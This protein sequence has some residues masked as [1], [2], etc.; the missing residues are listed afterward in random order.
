MSGSPRKLSSTTA[1]AIKAYGG[2]A[3]WKKAK[4]IEA[5]VSVSGLAPTLKGRPPFRHARIALD[6]QRP[7]VWLQPIGRQAGLIGV[8]DGADVQVQA[9]DGNVLRERKSARRYF[10]YGRRLFYWDD[11]DMSYFACYAFWNYF[12][13][14][15]LLLNDSIEW[16]EPAPGRLLATFPESIPTHS[17]RQEFLFDSETG[18]LRQ[19]NYTAEVISSLARAA[20]VVSE[21]R[22]YDGL[23]CFSERRV[24]PRRSNGAPMP[25]P[26]L[27]HIVVH[28]YRLS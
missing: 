15:N 13:F 19:H 22:R 28:K 8:L 16:Q 7:R 10:P 24:T 18:L 3:L 20:N 14:P 21:H 11:L 27:I 12:T 5:E 25:G 26:L 23:Q 1:R 17:A 4:R 6:V 9:A 2:E